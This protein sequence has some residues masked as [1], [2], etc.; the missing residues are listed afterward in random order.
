MYFL[1]ETYRHL[2]ASCRLKNNQIQR[3]SQHRLPNRSKQLQESYRIPKVLKKGNIFALTKN[4]R[5]RQPSRQDFNTGYS[6]ETRD[7]YTSNYRPAE[8]R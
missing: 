6:K 2:G 8:Q 5:D 3:N 4:D 1:Y 7:R